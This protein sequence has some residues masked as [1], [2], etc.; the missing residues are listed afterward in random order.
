MAVDQ[1][2]YRMNHRS[3]GFGTCWCVRAALPAPLTYAISI[4]DGEIEETYSDLIG[5]ITDNEASFLDCTL[6]HARP[7]TAIP[8]LNCLREPGREVDRQFNQIRLRSRR[9][10]R[11]RP[12]GTELISLPC[13]PLGSEDVYEQAITLSD[14]HSML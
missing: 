8:F 6:I 2:S 5:M 9:I 10:R 1:R 11:P 7:R 14:Q 3:R 4:Q 13:V 12:S